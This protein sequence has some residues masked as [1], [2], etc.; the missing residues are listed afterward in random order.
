MAVSHG[1]VGTRKTTWYYYDGSFVCLPHAATRPRCSSGSCYAPSSCVHA[2]EVARHFHLGNWAPMAEN[3][4]DAVLGSEH[5][6]DIDHDAIE[7][8]E[9]EADDVELMSED[10]TDADVMSFLHQY[11]LPCIAHDRV[12]MCA[13]ELHGL[14]DL[15]QFGLCLRPSMPLPICGCG[16]LYE[17]EGLELV[18]AD[19]V[20]YMNRPQYSRSDVAV[21]QQHCPNRKPECTLSFKPQDW[22][23][24][25]LSDKTFF[26][27]R[28]GTWCQV[29]IVLFLHVII[30][31]LG[32]S[33]QLGSYL[34]TSEEATHVPC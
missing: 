34:C 6:A 5:E 29:K 16:L 31:P 17:D 10:P 23:L 12:A 25:Q 32:A 24:F 19:C 26:A 2:K 21:L 33:K 15:S 22:G 3:A 30:L 7:G 27:A 4:D 9:D 1:P 11:Q 28:Y 18:R 14:A 13:L 8:G 20:V